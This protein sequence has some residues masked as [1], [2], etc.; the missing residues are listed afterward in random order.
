MHHLLY[1]TTNL[2]N[3]KYY[4]GIHS[5]ENAN[6]SYLGS[7]SL[8]LKAI[9]K[10]G[11]ENFKREILSTFKTRDEALI[12]E[13]EVVDPEDENSYNV[14]VGGNGVGDVDFR[15]EKVK[16]N[17]SEGRMGMKFSEEHCKNISKATTEVMKSK[18]VRNKISKSLI[19]HF[20]DNPPSK[21]LI[22]KRQETRA[23][24]RHSEETKRKISKAQAGKTIPEE[25]KKRMSEA[26]KNRKTHPWTGKKLPTVECPHCGKIGAVQLM[27]RWHFD[28]CK[29]LKALKPEDFE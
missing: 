1:K 15:S 9:A 29:H 13:H 28:N 27:G 12:A 2:V 11:K 6:D 14:D 20:K 3:G 18:E 5:T 8:I 19:E 23:G 22:Q 25:S 7:G 26:A 16:Q 4:Y 24:Y 17:I 10:Y 21:E